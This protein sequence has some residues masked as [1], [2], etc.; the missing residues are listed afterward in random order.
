M[1]CLVIMKS[2]ATFKLIAAMECPDNLRPSE[3]IIRIWSDGL[4]STTASGKLG[5]GFSGVRY[6]IIGYYNRP[7]LGSF[8]D[9]LANCVIGRQCHSHPRRVVRFVANL[10]LTDFCNI[11]SVHNL[12]NC[13]IVGNICTS[14]YSV[15]FE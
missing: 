12:V 5:F 6:S 4:T 3:S 10:N 14:E 1:H 9:K 15:A 11:L 13:G 8:N 2:K 7:S